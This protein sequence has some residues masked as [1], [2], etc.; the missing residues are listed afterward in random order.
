MRRRG[1]TWITIMRYHCDSPWWFGGRGG[2]SK[3]GV[4]RGWFVLSR[5]R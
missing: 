5:V 1:V 2:W 3:G 4:I